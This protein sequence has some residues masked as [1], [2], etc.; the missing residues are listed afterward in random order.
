MGVPGSNG[1]QFIIDQVNEAGGVGGLPVEFE[2]KQIS[3]TPADPAAA[4]RAV[5]EL[6][7]G[8]ADVLLG[9]PFSDYGLPLSR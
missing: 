9:P 8:G 2:I 7:D 3:Q 1:A 6:L 4:Q 5:Q